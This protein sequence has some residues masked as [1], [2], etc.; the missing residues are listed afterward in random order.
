M[1]Q[2][3]FELSAPPEPGLDNFVPGRNAEVLGQL[4]AIAERQSAEPFVYLW[5]APGCG[6]SHLLRAVAR[7]AHGE[8]C[9]AGSALPD[10][11]PTVLALDDVEQLDALGQARAFTLLNAVRDRGGAAIA[12]GPVPPARLD[13]R[14][15]LRTRLGWGIVYQVQLLSDQ[16]KIDW[17][18]SQADHRGL[19][20]PP[21]VS[22]YLL[23]RL[24]RDLASLS[25]A[26]ALLDHY[27][28]ARHRQIT[29][30][31]VREALRNLTG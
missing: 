23:K 22:S 11:T 20:W 7:I 8:Y 28:L 12:A 16:E 10:E 13:L 14:D 26:V 4:R 29:L 31:L 2:L 6:R 19:R 18:E 27:S 1:H 25:G 5:G 21:E 15:D 17:L 30:P 9:A 24:P 3:P